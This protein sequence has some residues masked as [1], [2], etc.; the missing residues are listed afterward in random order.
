MELTISENIS[1]M[2]GRRLHKKHHSEVLRTR[3]WLEQIFR[4]HRINRFEFANIINAE[5]EPTGIVNKWLK[6]EHA[7]KKNRVMRIAKTLEGSDLAYLLPIFELLKDKPYSTSTLDKLMAAY[8]V[9][10]GGL[11]CWK[12]PE[13]EHCEKFD[14]HPSYTPIFNTQDL[15]ERGDVYGFA[16][17]LYLLRRAEAEKK[18]LMHLEF[19][20][21]AYQAFPGMCRTSPIRNRWKE[22]LECLTIIQARVP[23]SVLLVRPNLDV[24]QKQIEAKTHI[25]RRAL[26]PRNKDT[27]RFLDLEEAFQCA[28][29]SIR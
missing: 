21:D 22:A 26:R 15:I 27:Q 4:T 5:N 16:G 14:L 17:I 10:F 18:A 24:I 3:I 11:K 1:R 19:I 13:A 20:K 2:S 28:E 25:T 9:D 29:F 6:G 7:V 23:T 12:F 8:I